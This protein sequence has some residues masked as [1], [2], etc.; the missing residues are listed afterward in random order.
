[1][2]VNLTDCPNCRRLEEE[3]AQLQAKAFDWQ[4]QWK[5]TSNHLAQA[6]ACEA[7][8]NERIKELEAQLAKHA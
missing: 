8:R 4:E 6:E 3:K 1:M 5:I 7:A 2:E